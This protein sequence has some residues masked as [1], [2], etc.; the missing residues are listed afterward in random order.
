M[1]NKYTTLIAVL[2]LVLIAL[3]FVFRK[4]DV[5]ETTTHSPGMHMMSDGSYMLNEGM[6]DM[7][8]SMNVS[9][10]EEFLKGMIPHH[11]EAVDTAREVLARGGSFDEIKVLAE[12]I[13]TSQNIEIEKMKTWH[14]E[15]FGAE[16]SPDDSYKPMMRDLSNLS[17][18][19][20]DKVFLEDMVMHHMGAVM[21]AQQAKS[22]TQREEIRVLS[23]EIIKAQNT[24]I[25]LMKDWLENKF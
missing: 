2:G 22:F 21:M 23:D 8:E 4:D 6:E 15:W 1:E 17:G 3:F 20:L 16:Y 19:D 11:Q 18:K 13:V 10:D 12:N 5:K 14:M 25:S 24:E 7:H 9:T